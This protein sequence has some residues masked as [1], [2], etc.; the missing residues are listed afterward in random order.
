MTLTA[1]IIL[2]VDMVIIATNLKG[3]ES[4]FKKFATLSRQ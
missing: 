2:F 1:H 4:Y 3:N